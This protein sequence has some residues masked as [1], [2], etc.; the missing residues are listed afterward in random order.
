MDYLQKKLSLF[1]FYLI[2]QCAVTL[3]FASDLELYTAY[4][5]GQADCTTGGRLKFPFGLGE[6]RLT[7]KG[8]SYNFGLTATNQKLTKSLPFYLKF[9]NLS[10]SGLLSKMN[11]PSLAASA[12]PFASSV[13]S[14]M[15][16]TA[17]LPAYT[18]FTKAMSFFSQVGLHNQLFS[19]NCA[20]WY[21]PEEEKI[22]FTSFGSLHFSKK[23]HFEFSAGGGFFPY[24]QS[25]QSEW[26]STSPFYPAGSHFSSALE[27]SC[28]IYNLKSFFMCA[29]NETPF[30]RASTCFRGEN[31]L[32]GEHFSFTGSAFF[33]GD[34][35]NAPNI[36]ASAKVLSSQLQLKGNLQYKA[37]LKTRRFPLFVKTGITAYSA[38]SLQNEMHELRFGYGNQFIFPA[39]LLQFSL[40]TKFDSEW[41]YRA[42]LPGTI[43]LSFDDATFQ[44]KNVWYFS[45]ASPSLTF[46]F[47]LNPRS[48]FSD[49]KVSF[50]SSAGLSM[51]IGQSAK[52][53]ASASYTGVKDSLRSG[54]GV[55]NKFSFYINASYIWRKIKCT[56]KLG[57]AFET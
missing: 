28:V 55:E 50:K 26:F 11:S 51:G 39:C 17:S 5:L 46:A 31:R 1:L 30:G 3:G 7:F 10:A 44:I 45:F 37:F 43:L 2:V 14:A 18:S 54:S 20:F 56:C 24:A 19:C 6:T 53:G 21:S 41:D 16:L 42:Q 29:L 38:I 8:D 40:V 49:M 48:D 15:G 13:S 47:S 34:L 12:A 25:S 9:G 27:L 32:A 52:T 35:P 23:L 57:F 4:E 36:T 33:N 22:A